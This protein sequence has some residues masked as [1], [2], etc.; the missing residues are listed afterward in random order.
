M[1]SAVDIV[2][3]IEAELYAKQAMV[4]AAEQRLKALEAAHKELQQQ[5]EATHTELA[6]GR[7]KIAAL[8]AIAQVMVDAI[9]LGGDSESGLAEADRIVA[10]FQKKWP[11]R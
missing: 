5:V 2:K 8:D 3:Q 4:T 6:K 9:G 11:K 1:T 10:D 7:D